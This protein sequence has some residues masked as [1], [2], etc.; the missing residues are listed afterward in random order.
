MD[1]GVARKPIEDMDAYRELI[2]SRTYGR[3]PE[4]VDYLYER[5]QRK[6]YLHREIER[7]VNQDRNT[8]AALLLALGEAD[9]LITGVTR[10]YAQ[11]LRQVRRCSIRRRA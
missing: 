8:F 2:N 9:A 7:M 4:M 6:G 1:T 3:V 11:S 5:L 10:P